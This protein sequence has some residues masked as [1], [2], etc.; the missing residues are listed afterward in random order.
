MSQAFVQ[1]VLNIHTML[2]SLRGSLLSVA[3]CNK[4]YIWVT[5]IGGRTSFTTNFIP[6]SNHLFAPAPPFCH[7]PR[8]PDSRPDKS[9]T[10][11]YTN[12]LTLIFQMARRPTPRF[13][14]LNGLTQVHVAF[15]VLTCADV[16]YRLTSRLN[17]AF[18]LNTSPKA[19]THSP[20]CL[21][22]SLRPPRN[23]KS[24]EGPTLLVQD[25]T[26]PQSHNIT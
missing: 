23:S 18:H 8:L 5:T 13:T 7:L 4:R 22:H 11:R 9:T 16:P 15:R 3:F 10:L 24:R 20:Q 17:G 21:R 12:S 6:R 25:T 1:P 2:I 26:S 19:A 14:F